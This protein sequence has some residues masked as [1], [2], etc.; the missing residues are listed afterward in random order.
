MLGVH[1][2]LLIGPTLPLPASAD[3]AEAV[4]SVSV[5]QNDEGRSGFQIVLQ[6]G[7]SGAADMRDYRLLQ[8]PLLRPF[9]RL[10]LTVLFNALPQQL[11]HKYKRQ[12]DDDCKRQS[13]SGY[14]QLRLQTHR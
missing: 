2:S 11:T 1:L 12:N 9:N 6:V 4:Q 14:H 10:I 7:R 5:T 8:N 3:I 13:G